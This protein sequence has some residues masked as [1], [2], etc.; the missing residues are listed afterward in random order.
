MAFRADEA[1]AR[2]L[3]KAKS[4]LTPRHSSNADRDRIDEFLLEVVNSCGPVVDAYPSWHPLVAQYDNRH[5]VRTPSID[6]GYRG[7]D[8]N[9]YFVNGFISCPY[10]NNKN[11]IESINQIQYEACVDVFVEDIDLPLYHDGTK[12]ILV[13]CEWD[14]NFVNGHF[15]S[16]ARAVPLMLEKE[17]P[18]WRWAER[19]ETWE[20]MR[21]YLLGTPHGARSSLF[22]DQDA[23][24]AI[25]NAY[26]ILVE[27]GMFGRI[28]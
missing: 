12:P 27:S 22:V 6:C 15:I 24:Q 18:V 4:Y 16:K 2:G 3:E 25:K 5:P 10:E 17:L 28:R 21:P 20:T 14:P 19:A 13:R 9:V 26:N 11:I 23:G 7:L 1:A 8:H